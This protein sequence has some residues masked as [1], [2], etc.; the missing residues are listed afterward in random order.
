MADPYWDDFYGSLGLQPNNPVA[1]IY[2]GFSQMRPDTP[3]T[4]V[5]GVEPDVPATRVTA[6]GLNVRPVTTVPVNVDGSLMTA[7]D[8][9]KT[10]GTNAFSY[11]PVPDRLTAEPTPRAPYVKP[12]PTGDYSNVFVDPFTKEQIPVGP[13]T[14]PRIMVANNAP[15]PMPRLMRPGSSS[16]PVPLMRPK[17]L[18]S[19]V[20]AAPATGGPI[21][22][23]IDMV[24]SPAMAYIG[25]KNT[26]QLMRLAGG[27]PAAPRPLLSLLSGMMGGGKPMGTSG[28]DLV[29]QA[30]TSR[31]PGTLSDTTRG[32]VDGTG[33]AL[34]GNAMQWIMGGSGDSSSQPARDT[35]RSFR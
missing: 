25:K 24:N 32:L 12:T 20:P 15:N 3:P 13:G 29:A 21:G 5:K 17:D 28:V 11:N 18:G 22:D 34:G 26:D 30:L 19:V 31:P 16:A 7:I 2:H 1:D 23:M 14:A 33:S 6:E 9:L 4:L 10:K 8:R 27:Q 35:S